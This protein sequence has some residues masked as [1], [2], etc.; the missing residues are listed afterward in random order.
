MEKPSNIRSGAQHARDCLVEALWP[1]RC[2][3]C[4][5]PGSILCNPCL[6]DLP[7][8]DTWRA[9]PKCGAAYGRTQC[10]E[11]N[12]VML[13]AGGYEK[14][15]FEACASALM[16]TATSSRIPRAFK[17]HGA[18]DLGPVMARLMANVLMPEWIP[19][20][21]AITFIPATRKAVRTRGFDHGQ[22]LAKHLGDL[23]NLPVAHLLPR[24][25]SI[26]QR[27]LSRTQRFANMRQVFR[28]EN[29]PGRCPPQR[30]LLIDD[31]MTTGSTL[32]A[33]T[34][35]LKRLGVEQ[36]RCVTLL[37]V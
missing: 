13:K 19:W 2:V 24:P 12:P 15:P 27:K 5:R 36:V 21:Q 4:D 37:R 14:L 31:V 16:F 28:E 7:Y 29:A 8:L 35:S 33:A 32:F 18:R 23:C 9:C 22:E 6:R 26:D 1:T 10:T 25:N 30:V 34:C 20:C 17:D 3:I 11:C